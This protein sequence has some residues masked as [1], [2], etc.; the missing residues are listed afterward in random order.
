MEEDHK[1]EHAFKIQ[2]K[3]SSK[4]DK[5]LKTVWDQ[6]WASIRIIETLTAKLL[7]KHWKQ[8]IWREIT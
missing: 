3:C 5:A 4:G 6:K 8:F 1:I 2:K 7:R